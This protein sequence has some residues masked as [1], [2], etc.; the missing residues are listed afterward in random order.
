MNKRKVIIYQ[1]FSVIFLFILGTL[2]HFT[3][4]WSN[5]NSIVALFSSIN[6][7]VWEHLKLVFFPMLI[8][9][10]IGILYFGKSFPNYLCAKTIG[11][12]CAMAFMIIFFY[13][14]TGILGNNLAVVDIS[15]FFFSVILGEYICYILITNNFV[16]NNQ[17]A[18][19]V[20]LILLLCFIIF[21]YHTPNIGLFKD[22]ITGQYGIVKKYLP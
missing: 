12:I 3:F 10:V 2:L 22:P 5:Q 13:T 14:Y 21:T 4:N 20:L 19:V 6:E 18:F 17:I 15:S 1:I 9:T 7:S 11:I 16:C 8:T